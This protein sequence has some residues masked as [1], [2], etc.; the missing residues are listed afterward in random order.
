M[1][2]SGQLHVPAAVLKGKEL[3]LC[4]ELETLWA[5]ELNWTFWVKDEYLTVRYQESK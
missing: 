4:I 3:L 2:V 1:E 5:Q